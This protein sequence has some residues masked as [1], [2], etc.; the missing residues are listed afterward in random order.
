ML[1]KLV[2]ALNTNTNTA[3][4]VV[5]RRCSALMLPWRCV[6]MLWCCGGA[7]PLHDGDVMPWY[8]D[9]LQAADAS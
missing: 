7:V 9:I 8:C 4:A 1:F 3:R 6:A 5:L 2:G